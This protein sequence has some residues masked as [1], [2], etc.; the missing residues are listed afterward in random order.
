MFADGADMWFGVAA[1]IWGIVMVAIFIQAIRLSYAVERRSPDLQ[2]RTGIPRNAMIF[3][4]V[5]NRRV[6]RDP[7]TQELRRR[8]NRLLLVNLIG[9]VLM[10]L[11][12]QISNGM[13]G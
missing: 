2:N 5:T 6:A 12:I 7:E 9:F 1:G 13:L 11:Y 4:T 8:M 3:H 10:F